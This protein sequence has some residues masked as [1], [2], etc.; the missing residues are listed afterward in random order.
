LLAALRGATAQSHSEIERLLAL[1]ARIGMQR[2]GQVI[3]GFE[4]FLRAWEP[5][6]HAALPGH[7]REWFDARCRGRLAR[8]DLETLG[9]APADVV[10]PAWIGASAEAALGSLYVIEGSALGGQVISRALRD[11][12][13]LSADRGA[14]FFN[15]WGSRTGAMWRE[16]QQVLATVDEPGFDRDA[17]C[18]SAVRTFGALSAVFEKV[19][20]AD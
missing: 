5:E 7:L 3:R 15:G 9:L 12:L 1:D 11:S 20:H 17:A 19:M 6:V 10:V 8:K 4:A 14:T 18:R 2:Y 13:G 16:F